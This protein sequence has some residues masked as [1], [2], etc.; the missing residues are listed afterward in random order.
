MCVSWAEWSVGQ[1]WGGVG[2]TDEQAYLLLHFLPRLNPALG[3][4]LQ[5]HFEFF[6]SA[7]LLLFF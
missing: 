7:H 2:D 5:Q 4:T 6:L 3:G 1:W